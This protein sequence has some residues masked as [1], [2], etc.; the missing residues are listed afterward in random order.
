M[1]FFMHLKPLPPSLPGTLGQKKD[2]RF[3]A[4]T[5]KNFTE[6][7]KFQIFIVAHAMKH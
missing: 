4:G 7:T 2:N 3:Q 1:Q 5:K 6:K